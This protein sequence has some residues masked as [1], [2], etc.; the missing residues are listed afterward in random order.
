MI[1]VDLCAIA[2]V[3]ASKCL[4]LDAHCRGTSLGESLGLGTRPAAKIAQEQAKAVSVSFVTVGVQR[5]CRLALALGFAQE[6]ESH[7][8]CV[9]RGA[10]LLQRARPCLH[11][12]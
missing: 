7:E 8:I 2:L 11:S 4:S 5:I 10:I 12:Q 9:F 3:R 6:V 1:Y